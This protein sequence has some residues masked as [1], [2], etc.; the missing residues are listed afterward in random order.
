VEGAQEIPD[1]LK[2]SRDSL[3]EIAPT[4]RGAR[5][6]SRTSSSQPFISGGI[7]DYTIGQMTLKDVAEIC[8]AIIVSLGGGAGIVFALSSYWGK[9]WAQRG[10]EKQ[11]QEYTRLNLEF[12]HQLDLAS[13]RVQVELDAVGHLHKLRAESEFEKVRELW[14]RIAVLRT[15]FYCIP[16][17]G[18]APV[19]PD[20]QKEH[21]YHLKCSGDFVAAYNQARQ[22]LDEETLS[23]PKSIADGATALLMFAQ[24]E[25]IQT[26]QYPDPFYDDSMVMFGEKGRAEWFTYRSENLLDFNAG[27]DKLQVLMRQHL[28]GETEQTTGIVTHP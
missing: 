18:G 21:E 11:R 12:T 13:R 15:A 14:K 6:P 24:E 16:K 2:F 5:R 1:I 27:A 17:A 26:V 22:L 3:R 8:G 20:K 25:A 23:I 7:C 9:V 4:G 19:N 10:L 28:Q